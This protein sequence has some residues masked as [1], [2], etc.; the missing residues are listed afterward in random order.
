MN[1]QR[2][3]FYQIEWKR[4]AVKST[5]KLPKEIRKKIITAIEMLSTNPLKGQSLVGG[6][7][8][9]KRIRIGDYRVIYLFDEANNRI[10]IIKVGSRGDIYK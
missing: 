9:L 10:L 4:S 6:L 5:K 2:K 7:Q 8:G 3:K 1:R